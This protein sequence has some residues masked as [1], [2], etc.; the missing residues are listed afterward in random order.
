MGDSDYK[1]FLQAFGYILGE[2]IGKGSFGKV[3]RCTK[4]SDGSSLQTFAVKIVDIRRLKLEVKSNLKVKLKRLEREISIMEKLNHKNIVKLHD[5]YRTQEA[6]FLVMDLVLGVDLFE[7]IVTEN[8]L[9]KENSA[10]NL[11]NQR[12]DETIAAKVFDQVADA[13]SYMHDLHIIHRDIKPE[14]IILEVQKD[15][16]VPFRVKLIDFGLSKVISEDDIVEVS[17]RAQAFG[18]MASKAKSLVGTPK[19]SNPSLAV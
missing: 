6:F 8:G 16:S 19:Y 12:Y 4:V 7:M 9:K 11:S 5:V 17:E 15:T 18:L 3:F 14:N 1:Q 13:I 10:T 2:V